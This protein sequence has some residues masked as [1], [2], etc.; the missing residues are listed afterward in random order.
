[1]YFYEILDNLI[2]IRKSG[3]FNDEVNDAVAMAESILIAA[4]EDS[5]ILDKLNLKE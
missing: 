5:E 4:K 3:L 2:A 1:M